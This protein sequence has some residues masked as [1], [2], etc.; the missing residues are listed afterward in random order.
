MGHKVNPKVFRIGIT[1]NWS[2]RWY[3]G[4]NYAAQLQED[5]KMRKFIETELRAASLD[6]V[7]I[8]RTSKTVNINIATG[9]PGLIIGRGG[10]GAE[11]LKAKLKKTFFGSKKV[12]ININI[13]E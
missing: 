12:S 9:K 7:I 2:S 3:S 8:E 13:K 11:D 6:S 10:Q 1:T 5:I 4:R